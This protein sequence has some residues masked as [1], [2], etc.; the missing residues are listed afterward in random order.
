MDEIDRK[1]MTILASDPR[2]H[3]RELASKLGVSTQAVH[4]RMQDLMKSGVIRGTTAG[5]S[6]RYLSAVPV[7]V[8]GR[9]N[10]V[11]VE[12]TVK[13]LS[14][15]ELSSSVLVAGGN[16]LYTVG[17]LHNISELDGYTDFVKKAAEIP[18]PTVGIY[19]LDAGLAPDFI[20]R[21]TKK[22]ESYEKLTPL[23]MRIVASLKEDARK[24]VGDIASEIGVS[25]K[26]VARRLENMIS[27]GSI[28]LV[29]PMDPTKCGDIVSLVH[30]QLKEGAGKKEVGRRLAS[31]LSPRLWYT[32][33]FSNLPGFL[34]CIVCT[35]RMDELRE[36]IRK[37]AADGE[38]K[39]VVPNI[40]YSDHIFETWRDRLVPPLNS[41]SKA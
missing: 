20:D 37:I 33:S 31:K 9:S 16:Y 14:A 40:W 7:I 12:D 2:I 27:E 10:T 13:K 25:A 21:G 8:F 5:I 6:I 41:G 18:E 4:R 38:V 32:R 1:L 23:D 39:S 3:F 36:V 17:L 28:D 34:H 11:S 19:S 30:V 26:T 29:V 24:P 35:D 15:N 22:K